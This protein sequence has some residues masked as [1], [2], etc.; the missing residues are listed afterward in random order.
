M[1]KVAG[2]SIIPL[3]VNL[4]NLFIDKYTK[5]LTSNLKQ[6]NSSQPKYTLLLVVLID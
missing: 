5:S 1:Y 3:L 6:V 2:N 4:V